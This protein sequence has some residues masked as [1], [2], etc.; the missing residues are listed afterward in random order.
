ME[1]EPLSTNKPF[2]QNIPSTEVYKHHIIIYTKAAK[3]FS[4]EI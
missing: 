2:S 1:F 4:T 3:N